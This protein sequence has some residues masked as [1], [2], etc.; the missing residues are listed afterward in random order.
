MDQLPIWTFV[1]VCLA[2][3]VAIV[4]FAFGQRPWAR[5]EKVKIKTSGV[6]YRTKNCERV[7]FEISDMEL[8]RSG[9]EDIRHLTQILLKL[10]K[11]MYDKLEKLID[12]RGERVMILKDTRVTIPKYEPVRIT[13]PEYE[14]KILNSSEWDKA[15]E[16]IQNK[17]RQAAFEVGLVWEDKP[18]KIKWKMITPRDY[19]KWRKA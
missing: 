3:L 18:N 8:R 10:D 12:F 15:K 16:G 19:G 17:L 7:M 5:R 9:E 11:D 14:H 1:I 2:L 13:W 6:T 4:S